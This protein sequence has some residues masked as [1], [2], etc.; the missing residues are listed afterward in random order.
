[1]QFNL[2]AWVCNLKSFRSVTSTLY[3]AENRGYWLSRRILHLEG[4][5]E[6]CS[7]KSIIAWVM[8]R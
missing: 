5:A 6:R 8:H 3:K 2:E 7:T 4:E 1:M